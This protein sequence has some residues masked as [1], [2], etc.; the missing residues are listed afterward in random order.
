MR[1]IFRLIFWKHLLLLNI[2]KI[3]M[4]AFGRKQYNFI[5]WYG[6]Q[7]VDVAI[8]FMQKFNFKFSFLLAYGLPLILCCF[9][10]SHRFNL[11]I[12]WILFI[13]LV[14]IFSRVDF[15]FY[16]GFIW[17]PTDFANTL[18][19]RL[20]LASWRYGLDLWGSLFFI[21]YVRIFRNWCN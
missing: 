8:I 16:C 4:F 10:I 1:W 3:I 11:L 21:I 15:F 18:Q 12:N 2:L 9:N 13:R 14:C 20:D 7:V 5:T 17:F 6:I 19:I